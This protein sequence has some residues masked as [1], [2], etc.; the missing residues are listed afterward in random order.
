MATPGSGKKAVQFRE[1]EELLDFLLEV[2]AVTSETLDLDRLLPAVADTIQRVIRH[3][4]L[5][6]LLYSDK[7]QGLRIRYARGHRDEVVRNLVIP[8]GEGITGT[9]AATRHPVLVNDVLTDPR[10]LPTLD[11]VR[12]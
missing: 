6:I 7:T 2:S 11:A 8:L 3:D 5:A 4:V 10:Y 12:S 1:R 9:A